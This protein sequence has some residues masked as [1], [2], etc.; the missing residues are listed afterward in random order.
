MLDFSRT[1]EALE[2]FDR[3]VNAAWDALGAMSNDEITDGHVWKA[4][5]IETLRGQEVGHAFGLDTA[6]RNSLET[7]E[8][9]VRPD[10]W[11]RKIVQE[12]KERQNA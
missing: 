1:A 4:Q 11:L 12:W 7:C 9:C 5:Q 8:M 10:A 3:D 6:D 2:K